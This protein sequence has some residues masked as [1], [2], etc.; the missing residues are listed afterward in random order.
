MPR[1]LLLPAVLLAGV[2]LLHGQPS[3]RTVPDGSVKP[4]REARW[5]ET[6]T[7]AKLTR[8]WRSRI[9]KSVGAPLAEKG[10]P[11]NSGCVM[12]PDLLARRFVLVGSAGDRTILVYEHGGFVSHQ[13]AVCFMRSAMGAQTVVAHLEVQGIATAADIRE[14]LAAGHYRAAEHY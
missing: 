8:S 1:F 5:T 12:S 13:H 3:P 9:E 7:L 4:Y 11:W 6:A 2:T 14:A 10:A